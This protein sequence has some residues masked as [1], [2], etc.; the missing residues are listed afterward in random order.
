MPQGL[1]DPYVINN[2]KRDHTVV[3]TYAIDTYAL[4]V[5]TV[6]SGTVAKLPDL[7]EYDHGTSVQLTARPRGGVALRCVERGCGG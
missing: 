3:V 6:G 4:T 7:P 5:N 2:V 1:N